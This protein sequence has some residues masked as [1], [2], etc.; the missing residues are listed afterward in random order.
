M[1]RGKPHYQRL[2]LD[3]DQDGA[4]RALRLSKNY[5]SED[6]RYRMQ[7][8]HKRRQESKRQS[9]LLRKVLRS[10]IYHCG[11]SKSNLSVVICQGFPGAASLLGRSSLLEILNNRMIGHFFLEL[12]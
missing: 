11:D 8:E 4:D 2:H 12:C 10:C 1:L 3:L 6:Q 9:K 5:N 7:S